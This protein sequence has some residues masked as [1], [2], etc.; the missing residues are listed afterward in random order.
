MNS[1][2]LIIREPII[3]DQDAF[4]SAMQASQGLHFPWVSPPNTPADFEKYIQR[5]QQPNQKSFLA[6]DFL[7]NIIGVF[8]ISE[9]VHGAFQSAYLGYYAVV[10]FVGKGLMSQALKLV[11][12]EIFEKM[13]LHRVEANIQPENTQSIQLVQS[14]GFSKEGLS[15]RYLHIHGAWRDHE[16]WALT[17]EDWITHSQRG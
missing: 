16:R 5:S 1:Q 14:N 8:N 12:S 9:I 13:H 4:V 6:C 3:E 2:Y 10:P 15:P 17:L 11:L 7:G